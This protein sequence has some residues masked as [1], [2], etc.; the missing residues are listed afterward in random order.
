VSTTTGAGGTRVDAAYAL[1]ALVARLLVAGTW[2]A[3]ALVLAGVVLMLVGGVDP[4]AHGAIPGFDAARIPADILA[5]RPEGFLWA[6]IVLIIGL[7]I[8]RVVVAG[9][10][11]LAAG[12]RRLALVSLLVFLVVLV[13]IL[14]ALGLEG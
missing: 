1:E 3:M 10:G 13:S 11:F 6:G 5:L 8:G 4:L 2:L 14:A 12:D 9:V 7:P